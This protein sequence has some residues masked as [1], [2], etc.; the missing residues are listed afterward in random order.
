[1][2]T[3]LCRR[4][5]FAWMA[6]ALIAS[7]AVP[8]HADE[9]WVAPTY[10][11]DIGGLGIASNAIWP[12]TPIGVVRLAWSIPDD[13]Q[14]FQI[15]KVVI[16]P[17]SSG[18]SSTLN[19]FVCPAQNGNAVAAAC[20]GPFTQAFSGVA[21][22]LVEVDISSLI[23]SRIGTP[24]NPKEARRSEPVNEVRCQRR[25]LQRAVRQPRR[26]STLPLERCICHRTTEL[27]VA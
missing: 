27:L 3:P 18:G 17:N 21:N 19:A 11:Q 1:M 23:A 20:G 16:I 25:R 22:Q 7:V 13:L 4:F 26:S 10:Q 6:C 8:A 9:I 14:T 2:T 5:G 24:A 15:A 12:V